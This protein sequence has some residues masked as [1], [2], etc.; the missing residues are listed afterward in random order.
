MRSPRS[1]PRDPLPRLGAAVA[2][3][4]LAALAVLAPGAGAATVTLTPAAG[5]AGSTFYLQGAGFPARG[6][7]ALTVGGRRGPRTKASATGKFLATLTAPARSRGGLDVRARSGRRQVAN[8][9]QVE[10]LAAGA[11]KWEIGASDG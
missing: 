2:G 10:K 9:F 5:P 11:T 4:T 7:V 6:S 3:V 1:F 8:Q